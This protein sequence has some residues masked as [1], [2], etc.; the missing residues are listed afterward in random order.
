MEP[1]QRTKQKSYT[2]DFATLGKRWKQTA[3]L[4]IQKRTPRLR[5]PQFAEQIVGRYAYIMGIFQNNQF[6]LPLYERII[7]STKNRVNQYPYNSD[8]IENRIQGQKLKQR[9]LMEGGFVHYPELYSGINNKENDIETESE[10]SSYFYLDNSLKNFLAGILDIR[11]PSMK[12]YAN[13]ASDML[14][15]QFNADALTYDDKIFFKTG[16]YDPRDKRGVALLGHE[17]THAVQLRMQNQNSPERTI[18]GHGYE[19]QE[20]IN[21]EKRVLHYF[22]SSELSGRNEKLLN[23]NP[24]SSYLI[25]P[26]FDSEAYRGYKNPA[27]TNYPASTDT[28]GNPTSINKSHYTQTQSLRT[29]LT[30]RDLSLPPETNTNSN[31]T[32]QLSEQHFRLI[33]DEVY[34]DIMNRIRIEFERGG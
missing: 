6:P 17:L 32:F 21:N 3:A 26:R 5:W 12:I 33:K 15:K 4:M 23:R 27:S 30:S 19:E 22:S 2:G 28:S 29:A 8:S 14:A 34:R 10:R 13:Q 1:E 18:A 16:K 11:I 25:E 31:S 7:D 24:G 9:Y 20:A